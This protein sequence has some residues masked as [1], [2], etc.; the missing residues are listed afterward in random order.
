MQRNYDMHSFKAIQMKSRTRTNAQ[1]HNIHIF[2]I[3]MFCM[4]F[5]TFLF[6]FLVVCLL[7]TTYWFWK[8]K[9]MKSPKKNENITIS[10]ICN[11]TLSSKK[12]RCDKFSAENWILFLLLLL[13]DC[14]ILQGFC[15]IFV[16]IYTKYA[17]SLVLNAALRD[18]HYFKCKLHVIFSFSESYNPIG[19]SVYILF[20]SIRFDNER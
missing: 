4:Q 3:L 14:L 6:C 17:P 15:E 13:F 1:M 8:L 9:K 7:T 5:L 11:Y 20:D 19:N 10:F 18:K 12:F 16:S 2:G